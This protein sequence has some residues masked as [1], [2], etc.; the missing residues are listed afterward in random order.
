MQ[1]RPAKLQS[2]AT[3]E[4]F[5][6]TGLQNCQSGRHMGIIA[7]FHFCRKTAA[8]LREPLLC[9]VSGLRGQNPVI[10]VI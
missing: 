7:L 4:N 3:V 9:E 10:N 5:D 6:G 1:Q 8:V 2:D